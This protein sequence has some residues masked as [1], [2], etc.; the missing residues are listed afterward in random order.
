MEKQGIIYEIV[1]NETADRYIGSTTTKLS[2]RISQH[3][4][5]KKN[6]CCSRQIINRNNY[7]YN[8]LE[9]I[10]INDI[11]ELRIKEREWYDKLDCINKNKPY[12]SS[13]ELRNEC[14]IYSTL[15]SK[16]YYEKNK[17]KITLY[18]NNWYEKNKE[19]IL[20]K[21]KNFY[22]NNKELINN[23][24]KAYYEANKKN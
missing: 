7:Y 20:E 16:N 18:K 13:E 23:R 3:K 8:I 21:R 4:F 17:D 10:I 5:I 24:T 1:C 12:R 14:L 22:I 19:R 11:K 9:T 15:H 6:M 2:K